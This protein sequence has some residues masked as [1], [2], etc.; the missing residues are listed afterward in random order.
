MNALLPVSSILLIFYLV[1]MFYWSKV[2]RPWLYLIGA[3]GLLLT[4]I[5]PFFLV[6]S[7]GSKS[8]LWVVVRVVV[9]AGNLVAFLGA[10]GACFGSSLPGVDRSQGAGVTPVQQAPPAAEAPASTAHKPKQA[11]QSS[12]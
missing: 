1:M 8:A 11:K 7:P 5:A 9:A 4:F 2:K 10:F 12:S 3:A 6:G